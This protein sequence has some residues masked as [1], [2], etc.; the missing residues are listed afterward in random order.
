MPGPRARAITA[1]TG[2][3]TARPTAASRR[4]R[5]S[6]AGTAERPALWATDQ[7]TD[8]EGAAPCDVPSSRRSR[9]SPR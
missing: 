8:T 5:P 6:P 4:T 2:T 3:A 7:L 9:P 1:L